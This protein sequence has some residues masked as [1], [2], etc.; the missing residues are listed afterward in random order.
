MPCKRAGCQYGLMS[1]L[2][3]DDHNHK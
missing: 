3:R 2:L 1:L